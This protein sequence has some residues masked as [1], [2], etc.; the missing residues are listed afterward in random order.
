MTG[1]SQTMINVWYALFVSLYDLTIKIN[2]IP[3]TRKTLVDL[4]DLEEGEKLIE[5]GVGTGR[6]IQYYP[7]CCEIWGVDINPGMLSVARYRARKQGNV[8]IEQGNAH[9]LKFE[10]DFFDAA[11]MTY[12]LSGIPDSHL[13]LDELER[14]VKPGGKI[15]ILDFRNIKSNFL[16]GVAGLDLHAVVAKRPHLEP[17]LYRDLNY[18][19]TA[20]GMYILRVQ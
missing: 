13:V 12:A 5:V 8:T 14:T 7:D 6:N 1:L 10:Q 20:L 4:L 11:L 19:S 17:V 15:G 9:D 2:E 3:G 18:F 16:G